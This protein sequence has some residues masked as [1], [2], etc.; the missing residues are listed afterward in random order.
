MRNFLVSPPFAEK[1]PASVRFDTASVGLFFAAWSVL[2][3]I[4]QSI[5]FQQVTA[6]SSVFHW[7]SLQFSGGALFFFCSAGLELGA[8]LSLL[9]GVLMFR[10]HRGGKSMVVSGLL[11]G[12]ASQLAN[13]LPYHTPAIDI[14]GQLANIATIVLFYL[15]AVVSRPLAPAQV[16]AADAQVLP[17]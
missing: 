9:G 11:L 2:V 6:V 10:L 7:E 16:P 17:G 5:S 13:I 8:V 15:M 12:L 14:V 3:L 4:S 1:V